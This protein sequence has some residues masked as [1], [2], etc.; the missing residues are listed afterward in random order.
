MNRTIALLF[1]TLVI[2]ACAV[3]PA[4]PAG[5]EL[6]PYVCNDNEPNDHLAQLSLCRGGGLSPF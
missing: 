2:P 5:V 1:L 6:N 3:Q 4:Q